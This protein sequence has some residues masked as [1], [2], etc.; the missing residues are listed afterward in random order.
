[1]LEPA[2]VR[3]LWC[4][5]LTPIGNDGAIDHARM[6]AHVRALLAQGVDG[7]APFGTT[8]EGPSFAVG[9]RRAGLDALLAA[10]IPASQIVAATGCAAFADTLVLTRH[11]LQAGCA[12]CLVLPP[13]FF[14][15]LTD[16]A[17]YRH[18]ATLIDTIGDARLSLYL[19]HIPQFSGV[20]L[21][22]DVVARLAADYP[23]VIAGVKD[24]GGDY[25]NTA[26]LLARV[27]KLAILVGH[28]PDLPRLM[29]AGG[30]GTICGIANTFPAVV[31]ALLRPDVTD[32]DERRIATLLDVIFRFPFLPAFKAI[33]AAQ[34]NDAAWRTLR[35][36][37][38]PLNEVDREALFTALREAG[39]GSAS[40]NPQ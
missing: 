39:F 30:A 24:S 37:L 12:R 22:P 4:A 10:G 17:I 27:P 31:R 14:K 13:F 35:P 2:P 40:E 23:R 25:A 3:G 11:A 6:T 18:Y 1:M 33:R 34:M 7:V 15:D 21:R 16:D 5:T 26:A 19:Y 28:E 20:P 32:L 36:P 8:G 38:F 9:E 29:R